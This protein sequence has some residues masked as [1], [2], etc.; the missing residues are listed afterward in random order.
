LV[1]LG[2]SVGAARSGVAARA[3]GFFTRADTRDELENL[4]WCA[5]FSIFSRSKPREKFC[6]H[7]KAWPKWVIP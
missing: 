2:G 4:I 3:G 1:E 7:P 6:L 5:T